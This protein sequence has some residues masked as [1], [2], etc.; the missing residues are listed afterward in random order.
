MT[1]E[2]ERIFAM[3]ESLRILEGEIPSRGQSVSTIWKHQRIGIGVCGGIAAY[4]VCSLISSLAKQD[5]DVRVFLTHQ[6]QTFVSPLTFAALSRHA[7][8][9]DKEYWDYRQGRP[10]HIELA[11]WADAL[12]IAPLSSNTLAKIAHGLADNLLTSV[13]LASTSPVLLAPAMNTQM[14]QAAPVQRN[15]TEILR[16]PRYWGVPPTAG[17][18]ACDTVG[19]GRLVEP[20]DLEE[21]LFALCWTQGQQDWQGKQVLVTAGGTQEPI[22]TVRFIG[23]PASGRMGIALARAAAY[24]GAQV[25]LVHGPLD[26]ALIPIQSNLNPLGVTSAADMQAVLTTHFPDSDVVLMAAAVGDVRPVTIAA[27]KLAKADLPLQ[28][29]LELI[30]D[31]LLELSRRK[32]PEQLL[33]G[34]AAQEG[35][36]LPAARDK[37]KRKGLDAIVANPIDQPQTG[38]GSDQNQAIFL[39]ADRGE[40]EIPLCAKR[41][42]AHRLLDLVKE[43]L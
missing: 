33:I 14:W 11:E 34:F 5:L 9:T 32:R 4:K 20:Q 39:T 21:A 27:S 15:W 24:R 43:K 2:T 3:L 16:D 13:L 41:E 17:R 25:L 10:L 36:I 22:D 38:F 23:N 35:N 19:D 31:L 37:L 6:A 30:P 42:M 40:W 12:L 18:L 7:V 1:G 28:L 26:P 29:Q 8:Y